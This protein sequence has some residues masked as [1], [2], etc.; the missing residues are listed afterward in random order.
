MQLVI[1]KS[2]DDSFLPSFKALTCIKRMYPEGWLI[3]P[4]GKFLLLFQ[5]DPSCLKKKA[6]GFIDKWNA[7]NGSPTTLKNR[8]EATSAEA[9]SKWIDLTENGWRRVETQFGEKAA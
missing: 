5:K 6:Y 4:K 1:N 8:K 9:I 7:K 3:D 2:L